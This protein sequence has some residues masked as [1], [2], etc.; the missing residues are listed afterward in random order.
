MKALSIMLALLLAWLAVAGGYHLT[1][2]PHFLGGGGPAPLSWII[3]F[4]PAVPESG[5]FGVAVVFLGLPALLMLTWLAAG[6]WQR[7]TGTGKPAAPGPADQRDIW[8]AG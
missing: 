6:L 1:G 4:P 3:C 8:L 5:H 2:F 7:P